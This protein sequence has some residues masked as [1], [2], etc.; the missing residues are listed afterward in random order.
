M[1]RT[2]LDP[3]YLCSICYEGGACWYSLKPIFPVEPELFDD[4]EI[5]EPFLDPNSILY[6]TRSGD[7]QSAT[8]ARARVAHTR[9]ETVYEP[10]FTVGASDTDR[11]DGGFWQRRWSGS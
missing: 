11:E 6:W 3:E 8:R 9:E 5:W 7:Y 1:C 4:E 10:C 2:R